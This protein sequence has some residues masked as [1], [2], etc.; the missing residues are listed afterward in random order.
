MPWLALHPAAPGGRAPGQHGGWLGTS[1]DP[2][3]IEGDLSR[4][5]WAVPALSLIDSVSADRLSRRFD[6]LSEFDRDRRLIEESA[7][8]LASK[9]H[10]QALGLLTSPDVRKAFDLTQEPDALRDRYGRTIHGQCALLARR[11]VEHD[12]PF[13]SVNWHNDG[14]TFWDTHGSNFVRLQND[15]IP[16]ADAALT[17][18]LIDLEERGM[19]D[20][21]LVVWVGEFGRTPRINHAA[22]GGREHHP[23]CYSGLLA[24]AGI[25]GGAVY[26]RSD[27]IGARPAEDPVSP[28]DL[29]A[30][31]LHA[32]G[33]AP[34][35]ALPDRSGRP[36]SLYAGKPIEALFS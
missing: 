29:A 4:P 14:Q 1:Y 22:N 13:V 7:P 8:F 26:G 32:F 36:I 16:P 2:L 34:E 28:H 3:L 23:F 19:L 10:E 5:D 25:R 17:T 11:L 9:R 12:V 18:L 24:G 21:T 31:M 15:L 6:L 35:Q 33:V 30:T 20:D 27:R